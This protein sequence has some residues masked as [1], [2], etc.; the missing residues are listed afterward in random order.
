MDNI[1]RTGLTAASAGCPSGR[2]ERDVPASPHPA[3]TSAQ[4]TPRHVRWTRSAACGRPD[5]RCPRRGQSQE[6]REVARS[7]DPEG[8]A[9]SARNSLKHGL[10]ADRR[11]PLPDE[12]GAEFA[13]LEAALVAELAPVGAL[14]AV[15]A[16]RVAVAAWR[17]ARADRIEVEA[18]EERH[19]AGGGPG[20]P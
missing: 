6:R 3:T 4:R 7:E 19:V 17:L 2:L 13:G 14:Q 9:R 20:S 11:V 18:S 12:D 15:L 1:P 8:N 10:R 5:Q 16:R